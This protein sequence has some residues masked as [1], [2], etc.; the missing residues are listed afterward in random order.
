MWIPVTLLCAFSLA[1]RDS[2]IKLLS[3]E[4][5]IFFLA[6]F[7]GLVSGI[8]TLIYHLL[9]LPVDP[10]A[11][12]SPTN[13][14]LLI[15]LLPLDTLAA[16]LYYLALSKSPL[17]LTVPFLAFTPAIIPFTSWILLREGVAPVAF[18]GILLVT[19]GGY[20]LF[21]HSF[22]ELL[23]PFRNFAREKGSVLMFIV[24]MIY[25]VTSVLGRKMALRVGSANLGAFYPIAS[26]LLLLAL[27][28]FSGRATREPFRLR[29]PWIFLLAGFAGAVMI[30]A[31][32]IAISMVN[33]AYM[34]SIKRTSTLFSLVYAALLFRERDIGKRLVGASIMLAGVMI[35][36]F[37]G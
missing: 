15:V 28:V 36:A 20:A 25:T 16:Y 34:I 1:T 32:F 11:F 4:H 18:A 27:F 9:F 26:A 12:F 6:V 2:A 13:L 10:R 24:A 30:T 3:R 19:I 31:H 14:P 22:R 35:I 21:F 7:S 8:A 23:G 33:T 17:S 5:S 29:R 37:F